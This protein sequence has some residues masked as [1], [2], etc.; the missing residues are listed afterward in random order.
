MAYMGLRA[1]Q[2]ILIRQTSSIKKPLRLKRF[3]LCLVDEEVDA[4]E[5]DN[6]SGGYKDVPDEV[7]I[8]EF[9]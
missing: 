4:N 3:S 8:F 7:E 6:G 5:V 2:V 1:Y 9:R